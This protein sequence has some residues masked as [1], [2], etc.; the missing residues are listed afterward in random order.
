MAH[1]PYVNPVQT[2]VGDRED[3]VTV[4]ADD[5]RPKRWL[6]P[7]ITCHQRCARD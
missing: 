3:R 7:V 4:L 2:G 6:P 1:R 5:Q